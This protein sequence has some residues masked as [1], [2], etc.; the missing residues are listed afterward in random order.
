MNNTSDTIPVTLESIAQQKA[1]LLQQIRVQKEIMTDITRDIF[2]PVA[3]A[4]NKAGA[5][6]RAFNTGMAVF[7]GMMLG[8]KLM[9]RIRRFF[10]KGHR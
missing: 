2:A 8:L 9:K 3:P 4:T 1:V 7:D 5:M 10:E 6:I